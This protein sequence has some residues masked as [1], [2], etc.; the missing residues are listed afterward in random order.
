MLRTVRFIL[1]SFTVFTGV[2][3]LADE[4]APAPDGWKTQVPRDEMA[5]RFWVQYP[6]QKEGAA[7]LGDYELGM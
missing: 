6:K 1:A 5:P 7:E 3:A 4:T 2:L